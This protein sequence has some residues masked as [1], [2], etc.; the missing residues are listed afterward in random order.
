MEA[1][2]RCGPVI[3]LDVPLGF[4]KDFE[5]FVSLYL[6]QELSWRMKVEGCP[7]LRFSVANVALCHC[8]NSFTETR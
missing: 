3:S 5:N 1:Q 8:S 7:A 6:F 2:D 4:R